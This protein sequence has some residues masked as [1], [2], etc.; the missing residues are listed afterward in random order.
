MTSSISYSGEHL[1]QTCSTWRLWMLLVTRDMVC[2][3]VSIY[4]VERPY[5]ML[6]YRIPDVVHRGFWV[7]KC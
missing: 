7:G 5:H 1:I 2:E 4:N 3:A 6:K